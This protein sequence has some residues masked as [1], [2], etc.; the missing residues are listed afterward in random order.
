VILKKEKPRKE[1][2]RPDNPRILLSIF[3]EKD[4]MKKFV[5]YNVGLQAYR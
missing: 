5:F 4:Q 3:E 2:F 1:N